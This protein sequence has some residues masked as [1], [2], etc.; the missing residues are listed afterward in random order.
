MG[1]KLFMV[2]TTTMSGIANAV[3]PAP[4]SDEWVAMADFGTGYVQ[5]WR[6][7]EEKGTGGVNASPVARVD[8]LDGGCCANAIWLD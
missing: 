7:G 4:W 8:I 6:L 1:K 5:I 3:T 2:P